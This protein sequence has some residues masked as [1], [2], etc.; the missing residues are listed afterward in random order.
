MRKTATRR[1]IPCW[2][3]RA[4]R[5][6]QPHPYSVADHLS[7]LPQSQAKPPPSN[8]KM[9]SEADAKTG[10]DDIAEIFCLS[11]SAAPKDWDGVDTKSMDGMGHGAQTQQRLRTESGTNPVKLHTDLQRSWPSVWILFLVVPGFLMQSTY[12]T[13]YAESPRVGLVQSSY[14]SGLW[15]VQLQNAE[16]LLHLGVYT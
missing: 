14:R 10:N 9:H 4:L 16:K 13:D 8:G 7:S 5:S 2:H 3:G 11:T 6:P 1:Q 15:V 12:T